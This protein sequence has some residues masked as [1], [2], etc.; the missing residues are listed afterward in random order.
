MNYCIQ[1][2]SQWIIESVFLFLW[3]G[4]MLRPKTCGKIWLILGYIT[5]Y[6]WLCATSVFDVCNDMFLKYRW[7]HEYRYL[8]YLGNRYSFGQ[9]LYVLEWNISICILSIH[10]PRVFGLSRVPLV[11]TVELSCP[12]NFPKYINFGSEKKKKFKKILIF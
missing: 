11:T 3:L 5:V 2:V 7:L 12:S 9:L 4:S 8:K 1:G 10:I 6:L